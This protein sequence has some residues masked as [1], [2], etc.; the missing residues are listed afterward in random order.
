M[1]LTPER[2]ACS[3]NSGA[4]PSRITVPSTSGKDVLVWE[5]TLLTSRLQKIPSSHVSTRTYTVDCLVQGYDVMFS[6][7]FHFAPRGDVLS[8]L[9]GTSFARIFDTK[10]LSTSLF[11]SDSVYRES[12]Q[13]PRP[14]DPRHVPDCQPRFSPT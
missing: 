11:D 5:G 6:G 14:G 12:A 10:G 1:R 13:D 4:A 2:V 9:I 7:S 8:C 3:G